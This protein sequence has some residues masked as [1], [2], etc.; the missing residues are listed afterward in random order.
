MD[1]TFTKICNAFAGLKSPDEKKEFCAKLFTCAKLFIA[2]HELATE[3]VKALR[4][5]N[6]NVL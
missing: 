3:T 6:E 2:W 5:E 1:Q 4:E